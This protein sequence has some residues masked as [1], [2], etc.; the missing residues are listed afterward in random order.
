[1]VNCSKTWAEKP[2]VAETEVLDNSVLNVS[3]EVKESFF[4]N[5]ANHNDLTPYIESTS[6]STTYISETGFPS[7]NISVEDNFNHV[8][9]EEDWTNTLET[10]LNRSI[11]PNFSQFY[12]YSERESRGSFEEQLNNYFHENIDGIHSDFTGTFDDIDFKLMTSIDDIDS[13]H[14]NIDIDPNLINNIDIES[15]LLNP[16]E[17]ESKL[18]RKLNNQDDLIIQRTPLTGRKMSNYGESYRMNEHRKIIRNSPENDLPNG[19]NF[20]GPG[21]IT[22]EQYQNYCGINQQGISNT[23]M[24]QFP[25][26]PITNENTRTLTNESIDNVTDTVSDLINDSISDSITDTISEMGSMSSNVNGQLKGN[27]SDFDNNL[28]INAN[29]GS[30]RCSGSMT[31]SNGPSNGQHFSNSIKTSVA[32]NDHMNQLTGSLIGDIF[33]QNEFSGLSEVGNDSYK[34]QADSL[35]YFNKDMINSINESYYRTLHN[36]VEVEYIFN[37]MDSLSRMDNLLTKDIADFGVAS[38]ELGLGNGLGLDLISD[39][40]SDTMTTDLLN[41]DALFSEIYRDNDIDESEGWDTLMKRLCI[42]KPVNPYP[43]LSSDNINCLIKDS[44]NAIIN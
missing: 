25:G 4:G 36:N 8:S 31:P 12:D 13:T 42:S 44:S 24:S 14:T 23:T 19:H 17:I 3:E 1:M 9:Q 34:D 5:W 35:S 40:S 30:Y 32:S 11:D 41:N 29:Y 22:P 18:V 21:G 20:S 7:Q 39:F 28:G 15:K 37:N 16:L 2:T 26:Q 43:N 33:H 10:C 38:K 6:S 27:G